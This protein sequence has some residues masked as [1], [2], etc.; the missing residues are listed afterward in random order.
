MK[1]CTKCLTPKPESEYYPRRL[2]SSTTLMSRC[3]ACM[4]QNQR[5][6]QAR[7]KAGHQPRRME[8]HP[9]GGRRCSICKEVKPRD[10]FSGEGSYCQPCSRQWHRDHEAKTRAYISEYKQAKG[11]K[12]CGYNAHPFA[13]DFDHRD[14]GEKLMNVA[15]MMTRP[16]AMLDAEIAKCDVLCANC[17]RIKTHDPESA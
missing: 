17:H 10:Q 16:R 13:L 12:V 9:C 1:T 3:K 2:R 15:R 11:C 5:E 8:R 7:L 4:A 14:P 6:Y